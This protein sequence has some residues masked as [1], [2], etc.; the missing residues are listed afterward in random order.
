M[1]KRK[2]RDPFPAKPRGGGLSLAFLPLM[3]NFINKMQEE[4]S[5]FIVG[6]KTARLSFFEMHDNACQMSF[7]LPRCGLLF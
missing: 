4:W 5:L 7:A 3:L 2:V 1:V 6:R